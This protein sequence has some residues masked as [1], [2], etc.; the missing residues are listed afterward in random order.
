MRTGIL[1]GFSQHTEKTITAGVPGS[2]NWDMMEYSQVKLVY[3]NVYKKNGE[4]ILLN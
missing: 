2:S 3:K 4:I 1:I